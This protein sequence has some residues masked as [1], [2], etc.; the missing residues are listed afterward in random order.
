MNWTANDAQMLQELQRK[1]KLFMDEHMPRLNRV[2]VNN[3]IFEAGPSATAMTM[4]QHAT[5]LR[6]ALLPFDTSVQ[7]PGLSD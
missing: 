5:E 2:V 3:R 4:V 7:V 6:E 1:Q